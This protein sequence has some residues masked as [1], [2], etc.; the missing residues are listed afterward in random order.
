MKFSTILRLAAIAL[1]I[2]SA[3]IIAQ[4]GFEIRFNEDI[5]RFFEMVGEITGLIVTPFE[6]ILIRPALRLLATWGYQIELQEHWKYAFI[7]LWLFTGSLARATASARHPGWAAFAWIWGGFCALLAGVLAGT[8]PLSDPGVLFRPFACFFLFFVGAS[9]WRATFYRREGET[10]LGAV[11][12]F[13]ALGLLATGIF[14]ILLAA[15]IIPSGFL[16]SGAISAP[17][18]ATLT[19]FIGILGLLYLILGAF[20]PGR[21]GDTWWQRWLGSRP[22]RI[23]LDVLAVLGGAAFLTYAAHAL[24]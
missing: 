21:D 4:R 5:L 15:G 8:V 10:W 11:G 6:L 19:A 17:G 18:L 20:R 2:V 22:A 23:G 24:A 1:G 7:L 13:G 12:L 9:A 16:R 14:S 3:T